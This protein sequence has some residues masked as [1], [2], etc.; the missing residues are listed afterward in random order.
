MKGTRLL[1][2][3]AA[4]AGC[5]TGAPAFAHDGPAVQVVRYGDLDIEDSAGA[6]ILYD[7]IE[8]AA[9]RVCE[10]MRLQVLVHDRARG[11]VRR[12]VAD[13]VRAVRQ[14]AAGRNM[15]AWPI[16]SPPPCSS[17]ASTSACP[18]RD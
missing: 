8:Q 1:A 10:P 2:A 9:V 17:S 14:Q 5:S 3:L 6:R 7:R 12:A 4:I 18:A 15:P 16:S 11:C 13:A